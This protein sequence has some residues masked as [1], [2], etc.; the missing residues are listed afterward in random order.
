[1]II[2]IVIMLKKPQFKLYD[3]VPSESKMYKGLV[4]IIGRINN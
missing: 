3:N 1:M 4:Q 2:I